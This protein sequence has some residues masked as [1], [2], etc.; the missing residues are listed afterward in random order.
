MR[1]WDELQFGLSRTAH[2]SACQLLVRDNNS[3]AVYV[4][5]EGAAF[6]FI[7]GSRELPRPD[8]RLPRRDVSVAV[9]GIEQRASKTVHVANGLGSAAAVLTAYGPLYLMT[10][11][12][13]V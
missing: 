11:V 1:P 5:Y 10:W 8:G 4:K 13:L 9:A 3:T 7:M 2:R 12:Q 6:S